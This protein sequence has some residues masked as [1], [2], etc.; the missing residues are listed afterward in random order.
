MLTRQTFLYYPRTQSGG[1][2]RGSQFTLLHWLNPE[3]Q[4]EA[5]VIL[6]VSFV[7]INA[8]TLTYFKLKT[9]EICSV[10]PFVKEKPL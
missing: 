9:K 4:N 7:T 8:K 3:H 1:K 6:Y 2:R 10:T 5:I